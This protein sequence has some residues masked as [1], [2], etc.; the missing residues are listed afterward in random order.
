LNIFSGIF[1]DA[2]RLYKA[3]QPQSELHRRRDLNELK[4]RVLEVEMLLGRVPPGA[5]RD[6]REDLDLALKAIVAVKQP[7]KAKPKPELCMDDDV[8]YI[9]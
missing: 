7:L 4:A 2:Q 1:R 9:G 5:C 6:V 8:E 3:L